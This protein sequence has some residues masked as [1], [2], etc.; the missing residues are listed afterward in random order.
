VAGQRYAWDFCKSP[1][2]PHG[3]P[4]TVCTVLS[5]F[6]PTDVRPDLHDALAVLGSIGLQLEE[7]V[8]D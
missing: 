1:E 3:P 4:V 5:T 8:A 2:S 6:V 7:A